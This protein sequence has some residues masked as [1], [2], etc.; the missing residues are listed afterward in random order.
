MPPRIGR[1]SSGWCRP[2]SAPEQSC[3]TRRVTLP[4]PPQEKRNATREDTQ[5]QI[6]RQLREFR[7]EAVAAGLEG[8]LLTEESLERH[9]TVWRSG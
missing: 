3:C 6:E 8:E 5:S 7:L 1:T 9:Q 4:S 2:L